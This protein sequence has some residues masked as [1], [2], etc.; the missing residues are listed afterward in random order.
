MEVELFPYRTRTAQVSTIEDCLLCIVCFLPAIV[1]VSA[2]VLAMA[3]LQMIKSASGSW[4]KVLCR[5][6]FFVC[7]NILF[8]MNARQAI[9]RQVGRGNSNANGNRT[10]TETGTAKGEG[11]AKSM[12]FFM[13]SSLCF[14]KN[15]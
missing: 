12:S 14:N 6:E 4:K 13:P 9:Y 15:K 1:T 11:E 5:R 10:E 7:L 8:L 3:K 2:I